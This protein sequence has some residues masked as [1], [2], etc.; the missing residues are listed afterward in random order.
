M[1]NPTLTFA[2]PT[3]LAGDRSLVSLV[4]H[5]LAHSWSGNL[6]TNATW[7][8]FWLNEG[9]TVY[10]ERRIMEAL[11]GVERYRMEAMLG[12]DE[13]VEEMHDLAPIDEVLHVDLAGRDPD[14]GFTNVPY[15]KGAA[16]LTLL[17]HTFGRE[18]F[19]A[20]LR[21]YFD[22][23]AFQSM[24][25]A[26]F[27]VWLEAHLFA[28]DPQKA[29]MIDV[30]QWI[31]KPGLPEDCPRAVSD[32]FNAVDKQL[33]QWRTGSLTSSRLA[34]S[35]WTTHEWLHFLRGLKDDRGA[36]DL[37]TLDAALHLSKSQN[38]EITC[39]WLQAAIEHDYSAADSRLSEFLTVQGRRKFLK[40]LYRA[41]FEKGGA[42][43]QQAL[44]IYDKARP[45]YHAISQGTL[46][47]IL[48]R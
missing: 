26:A 3:I 8:D 36:G 33:E 45:L 23:H 48:G 39:A 37:S 15:E 28:Q 31:E 19:D 17:E 18:R 46:D 22:A 5:E 16:F 38:S 10:L 47:T 13:L 29:K 34:T 27:R 4:A 24:T 41:L 6:V 20:F 30:D 42:R 25:T 32:A 40:P 43:R 12:L 14:E 11:F 21:G 7:R 35:A 9:F 1:E 44:D 2:T